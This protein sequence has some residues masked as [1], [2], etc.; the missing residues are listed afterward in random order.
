MSQ[1]NVETI[2]RGYEH[3]HATGEI[4]AHPDFIWDVS[5]LGWPDQQIYPGAEGA[6]RFNA[7]WAD[8]WDGW[9]LQVEEYIDAGESV[10][11]IVTQ[12]GRSKTTGIPVDMRFAQVW[13]FR[14][15]QAIGMKM[16]ADTEEALQAAGVSDETA[17][18]VSR[19]RFDALLG[20]LNT[21][22][23]GALGA[24]LETGVRFTSLFGG[25]DGAEPYSGVEGM[26]D[27]AEEVDA[28]WDDWHQEVVEFR[29]VSRDQAVII[30]RA[31]G[32][33]KGSGVPLDSLTG[34]VLTRRD[35]GGWELVAYT[36]PSEAFE[37][38]GLP[39]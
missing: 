35:D 10:V 36:D 6:A 29:E 34:N 30:V 11:T 14:D 12:R 17:P 15:G 7:E 39:G 26:R 21:R 38:V 2:R 4:R 16:Y 9:E 8:A 37:A 24:L 22:D 31:T 33:A 27:W 25:A 20:A 28:V 18:R 32:R 1:Q 19:E 5:G 3:W 13:T 23:F